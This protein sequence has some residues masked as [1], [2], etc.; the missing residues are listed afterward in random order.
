MS[1]IVIV[2]SGVFTVLEL[3]RTSEYY[4]VKGRGLSR[5]LGC[6][7]VV[8]G[9]STLLQFLL[10]VLF[11]EIFAVP[12]VMASACAFALSAVANYWL[13]YH[14]TFASGAAHLTTA[15]KFVITALLGLTIN[16]VTF[17][18]ALRLL[19]HYFLAQVVAVGVTVVVN[20]AI[21]KLWI[22]RS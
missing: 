7:L 11:H 13:N 14:W 3:E 10:L 2:P 8:G 9:A 20:F 5:E 12:P 6:F 4:R 22:Y 15:P 16:T 1:V 21:H 17:A 19:P 18:L